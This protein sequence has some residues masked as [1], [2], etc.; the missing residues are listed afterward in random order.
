MIYLAGSILFNSY[1]VLFFIF[2][3]KK[4]ITIFPIIVINY[5]VCVITGALIF[6]INPISKSIYTANWFSIALILGILFIY[7]FL[8]IGKTTQQYGVAITSVSNKLSLI[9]PVL[10]SIIFF[11]EKIRYLNWV[12]I[13]I[14]LVAVYLI[15]KVKNKNT[16]LDNQMPK[17][18]ILPIILFVGSGLIDTILNYT[19]RIYFSQTPQQP[20]VIATFLTACI[21]GAIILIRLL[22]LKKIIITKKHFFYGILL[23]IPNFFSILMIM[24][25]LSTNLFKSSISIALQNICIVLFSTIFAVIFFKEKLHI[26]N[27]IGLMLAIFSLYLISV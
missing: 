5:L 24:Q 20:F 2:L 19:Q 25:F 6:N 22:I 12:G 27:W 26:L 17:I 7:I 21:A 9:I 13:F 15:N 3:K 1:I 10:I 16:L 18:P 8:I 14:A 11:K 4:N 23:G